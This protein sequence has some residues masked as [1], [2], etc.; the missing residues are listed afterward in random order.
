MNQIQKLNQKVSLLKSLRLEI[1]SVEDHMYS[2]K[3]KRDTLQEEL[4]QELHKDGLKQWKTDDLNVSRI[5]KPIVKVTDELA[6]MEDLKAKDL[7]HY[8]E[9]KISSTFKQT[10]LPRMVKGGEQF[11]G[12]AIEEKEY[13]SVRTPNQKDTEQ[14]E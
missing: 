3:A 2:L 7:G 13:L 12:I 14:G 10:H 11:S 5:V 9:T 4:L 1:S 8:I 6:L